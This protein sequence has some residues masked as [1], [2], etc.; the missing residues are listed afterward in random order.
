MTI[1]SEPKETNNTGAGAINLDDPLSLHPTDITCVTVISFKLTGTEN[2]QAWATA[3]VRALTIRNKLGFINGTC[4]RPTD[5]EGSSSTS[6]TGP[7]WDRANAVVTSWLLSSMSDNISAAYVLADNARTLWLE[8][9]ETFEKING[10]VIY[11]AF[12]K[13]NLHTQ[14]T[15]SVSDY[16]NTLNGLW[17][18]FDSL[19]GVTECNCAAN[20][21]RLTLANKIKLM[22]FLMGLNDSYSQIRSNILMLETLPTVQS[23]FSTISREES[24]KGSSSNNSTSSKSQASVFASKGPDNK[25]KNNNRGPNPNLICKHCNC[26]GHT[27]DRCYKLV[28]YPKDFKSKKPSNLQNPTNQL[29]PKSNAVS[30]NT[31]SSNSQPTPQ[32][33]SDQISRLLSLLNEKNQLGDVSANMSG[34]IAFSNMVKVKN[35][36]SVKRNWVVDSGASQHMTSTSNNLQNCVDVSD[37]KLHVDHPNGTHAN[38]SQIGNLKILSDVFLSDVLVIPGFNIDLL[39]VH[40]LTKDS[41][42]GV[43][44]DEHKCYLVNPQD[45]QNVLKMEIGSEQEGLYH[46]SEKNRCYIL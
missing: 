35:C 8:L 15:N 44:F 19:A 24:H 6:S 23:A 1:D 27:I 22:Q 32:L 42:Y 7:K 33:S 18:E 9:K 26:K 45:L 4:L 10:S 12:Q 13:I 37:L 21:N 39:S 3:T 16:F 31:G 46:L 25:D 29:P 28:G 17:K 2:Y 34:N 5:S 20:Q 11:N 43:Y 38:I 36:E 41:S 30:D 40:K 14:G